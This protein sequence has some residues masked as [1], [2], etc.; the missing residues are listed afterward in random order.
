VS[1]ASRLWI[2]QAGGLLHI[3]HC[4]LFGWGFNGR[5]VFK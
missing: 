5:I 3:F 2:E 1:Q 4:Q